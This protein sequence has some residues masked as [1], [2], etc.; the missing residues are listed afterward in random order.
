MSETP[1]PG[2]M[3]N[4]VRQRR[5]PTSPSRT[6]RAVG[7]AMPHAIRIG[8]A[9]GARGRIFEARSRTFRETRHSATAA[10]ANPAQTTRI[11]IGRLSWRPRHYWMQRGGAAPSPGSAFLGY[12]RGV[13]LLLSREHIPTMCHGHE[14][15]RA[16][17]RNAS[18]YSQPLTFRSVSPALDFGDHC[19]LI[20][21]WR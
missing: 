18:R 5:G 2:R 10:A 4:D 19:G 1:G 9:P 3:I 11:K 21:E 16:P 17:A 14:N 12:D 6:L 13:P 15:R 20:L 8:E 7:G